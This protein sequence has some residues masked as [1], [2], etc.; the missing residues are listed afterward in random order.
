MARRLGSSTSGQMWFN[1]EAGRIPP[2]HT[3]QDIVIKFGFPI[4]WIYDG[5]EDQLNAEQTR[6]ILIGEARIEEGWR[7]GRRKTSKTSS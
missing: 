4:L 6:I 3:V 7:P 5:R 2:H 1:Y